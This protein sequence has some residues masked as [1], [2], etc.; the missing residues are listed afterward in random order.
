MTENDFFDINKRI[1]LTWFYP[2][3]CRFQ[4]SIE[5]R[6]RDYFRFLDQQ[7]AEAPLLLY[8]H[9][10]FCESFC[11]YCPCFK[12]NVHRY[13]FEQREAFIQTLI[14]EL[15]MYSQTPFIQGLRVEHILFGGGSPSVLD[16]GLLDRIFLSIEKEFDLAGLK[17][18]SFEGNVMSL[19]NSGLLK[20]LKSRGVKRVSFGLQTMNQQ[21]RNQLNIKAPLKDIYQTVEMIRKADIPSFTLDK[22]YNLPEETMDI[23]EEDLGIICRELRP[24]FI[25]T[26]RFNQ[27]HNTALIKKIDNGFFK[28]PPSHEKEMAMFELIME[29][30]RA[31]GYENQMFINFF[32]GIEENVSCGLELSMGNNRL[33]GSAM[34]GLGPGSM[35]YLSGRNYRTVCS[36]EGY[37]RLVNMGEYPVDSGNVVSD[38]ELENRTM[39]FFPN[40]TRIKKAD[41]PGRQELKEHIEFL[42][43]NDL[44]TDDTTSYS[45][46]TK[47]KLWAGNISYLFYSPVEKKRL[48]ES[49]LNSLRYNK[50][51]FNQ[52]D[53][54]V[55]KEEK[56]HICQERDKKTRQRSSRT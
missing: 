1:N 7:A 46:T 11:S 2:K 13:S 40:F 19:K 42:L 15:K 38:E 43:N 37:M 25:Q 33:D 39:V 14:K 4:D 32:S 52:D 17:G 44:L 54:N 56:E 45:L 34:L 41:V 50:N 9:I 16:I 48:Q 31:G 30:L 47:G 22:M 51:P 28:S 5:A 3:I 6:R 35:S 12:E 29:R 27:F 23:L 49:F 8:I 36:I 18:I 53:M 55:T 24:T 10:P 20:M 26:Y 21:I